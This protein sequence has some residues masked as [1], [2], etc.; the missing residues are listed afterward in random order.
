MRAT[1]SDRSGRGEL[2]ARQREPEVRGARVRTA[3]SGGA[4][5]WAELRCGRG[6]DVGGAVTWAGLRRGRSAGT[7]AGLR[8][9]RGTGSEAEA[10]GRGQGQEPRPAQTA[11]G[12]GDT[13]GLTS[14]REWGESPGEGRR[15]SASHRGK[16]SAERRGR[17]RRGTCG[18]EAPTTAEPL[19]A[20]RREPA[21]SQGRCTGHVRRSRPGRGA[22]RRRGV[23]GAGVGV[24][25]PPAESGWRA[26][27]AR[28]VS[29]VPTLLRNRHLKLERTATAPRVTGRSATQP[30]HG[31]PDT[32]ARPGSTCRRRKAPS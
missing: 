7:W 26:R 21:P 4:A 9:G 27:H 6:C 18:P 17:L 22:P 25:V 16:R 19:P 5:M 20:R 15:W 24:G 13:T 32:S 10:G 14:R 29:P 3:A 2:G 12:R 30:M 11:W 31:R 28:R 8:P 23:T 1:A